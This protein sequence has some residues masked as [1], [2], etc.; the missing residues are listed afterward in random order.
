MIELTEDARSDIKEF[1]AALRAAG[2]QLHPEFDGPGYATDRHFEEYGF[3]FLQTEDQAL[4][5][6]EDLKNQKCSRH[7]G[8][9]AT[10]KRYSSLKQEGIAPFA[11]YSQRQIAVIAL[12]RGRRT[13]CGCHQTFS[14]KPD[15][16]RFNAR[17]SE[18]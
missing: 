2:V 14:Y 7:F 15:D 10:Y 9:A 11:R 3:A 6:I 18:D 16:I 1:E 4:A 12:S 5:F 13:C 17:K 8:V